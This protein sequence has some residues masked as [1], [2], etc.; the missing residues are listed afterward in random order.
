MPK[1]SASRTS[2]AFLQILACLYNSK[3][4]EEQLFYFFYEICVVAI[5]DVFKIE[6]RLKPR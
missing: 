5:F 2:R 1:A 4:H 6:T 3:T